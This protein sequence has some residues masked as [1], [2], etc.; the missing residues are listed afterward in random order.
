MESQVSMFHKKFSTNSAIFRNYTVSK[1]YMESQ[2]SMFH[3]KFSTNSALFHNYTVSKTYMESQ[4]Y[5]FHK[6]FPT[7]SA[8]FFV[9]IL[10]V[11]LIWS[12]KYLCFIKY[13]QQIVQFFINT[14]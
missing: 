14:L 10:R 13:F 5:M 12:L 1:A 6:K 7:N 8:I 11:K 4:I 9:A 2:L 3:K